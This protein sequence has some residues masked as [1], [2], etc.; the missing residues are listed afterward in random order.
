LKDNAQGLHSLIEGNAFVR[1][2]YDILGVVKSASADD[3][4]TAY[5]KLAK[6]LH[7]DLNPGDAKAEEKFKAVSGAYDLLSDNEKRA[8]FDAGVI[9]AAGNEKP[10]AR[11]YYR[12]YASAN[13]GTEG[14]NPNYRTSAGFSDFGDMEDVFAQMF[15]RQ[16]EAR[17]NARGADSRYRL[18]V[19][20]LDAV[21]GAVQRLQLPGG[22]AIEV[23]IPAG[24]GDGQVIRLKGKGQPS[25]GSG[26]AGDALVEISVEPHRFFTRTNDDIAL[27]LP[28]TI[29]EAA[30]GGAVKAPTPSGAV[31]LNV[32]ANSST[33]SQLRLKGKGVAGRGDLLVR[34]KV[35]LPK[36]PDAKLN[37]FLKGWSPSPD[38]DPRREM[39]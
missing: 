2:P 1:D 34:L 5:R 14:T 16:A 30:L 13:A 18:T 4:R 9:D 36:N 37:D 27:E 29:K 33:G 15:A 6:K 23:R 24:I 28:V 22:S 26:A 7:P 35:V 8:R 38:D 3:I 19:P 10:Q 12:N 20:F 11:Q 25:Q 31:M 17:K 39:L 32:P 21:N